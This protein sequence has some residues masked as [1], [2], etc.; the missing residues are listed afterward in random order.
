MGLLTAP[1]CRIFLSVA[2][3]SIHCMDGWIIH[4]I[5]CCLWTTSLSSI[6]GQ[7]PR[8]TLLSSKGDLVSDKSYSHLIT[9]LSLLGWFLILSVLLDI[10]D[11]Y[12]RIGDELISRYPIK[13]NLLFIETS[14]FNLILLKL[15]GLI[16]YT[17]KENTTR[18][19]FK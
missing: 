10:E 16:C 15:Y 12:G 5:W 17:L 11:P 7:C 13:L 19:T 1:T 8:T 3:L 9:F 18:S 14:R 4:G 6:H 2:H